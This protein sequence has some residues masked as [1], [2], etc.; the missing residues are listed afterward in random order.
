MDKKDHMV[1]LQTPI[2]LVEVRIDQ[3]EKLC[4]TNRKWIMWI[5]GGIGAAIVA[6]SIQ[7]AVVTGRQ[8][9]VLSTLVQMHSQL[10]EI[11]NDIKYNKRLLEE[12][13]SNTQYRKQP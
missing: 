8:D 6:L 9:V 3:H 12:H 7:L 2:D 5:I 11:R 10:S 1:A 4:D 13:E